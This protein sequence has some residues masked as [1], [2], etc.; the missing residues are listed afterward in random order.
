MTYPL[1]LTCYVFLT[2]KQDTTDANRIA[3][4]FAEHRYSART[5]TKDL[6]GTWKLAKKRC[7][8]DERRQQKALLPSITISFSNNGTYT[9]IDSS[10]VIRRGRWRISVQEQSLWLELDKRY[11]HLDENIL[12]CNDELYFNNYG[13]DGC[14]FLY[15]RVR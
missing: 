4:C 14:E 15:R 7:Y 11:E 1:L 13:S 6:I 9:I 5:L 8:W 3:K 2:L 12:V 10:T